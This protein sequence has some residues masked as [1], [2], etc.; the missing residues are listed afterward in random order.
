MIGF[1]YQN[2]FSS[3]VVDKYSFDAALFTDSTM[4]RHE[5]AINWEKNIFLISNFWNN[6]ARGKIFGFAWPEFSD[7]YNKLQF[8]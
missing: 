7:F 6:K 1:Q 2:R 4:G 3:D 5:F 8:L